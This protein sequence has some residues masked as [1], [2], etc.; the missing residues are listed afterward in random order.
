MSKILTASDRSILIKL[1][2]SM[3][4]GS[5]ERRAILSGLKRTAYLEDF[6]SFWEDDEWEDMGPVLDEDQEY[7]AVYV[8][9][10]KQLLVAV[11]GEMNGGYVYVYGDEDTQV[12]EQEAKKILRGIRSPSTHVTRSDDWELIGEM[13]DPGYD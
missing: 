11:A 5:D 1:A 3:D 13:E 4:K 9:R 8:S 10:D 6:P 7:K 12:S 2:S